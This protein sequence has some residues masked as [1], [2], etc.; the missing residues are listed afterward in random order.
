MAE[1]KINITIAGIPCRVAVRYRSTSP[2]LLF[3]LHGLGCSKD[4]FE[5]A[6]ERSDFKGFSL[7]A[8]DLLGFGHSD[9]PTD[10]S[11]SLEDHARV[12]ETVLRTFDEPRLHIIAHSMGGAVG[13]LLADNIL[14]QA[15]TF[16]NVEGNL[17]GADCGFISRK[18]TSVPYETFA[19]ELFPE[20]QSRLETKD[21]QHLFLDGTA[22]LAFYRSAQSLVE[23]SDSGRLLK[24][25][26][27]L[28]CKKAY[29]YG[30]RNSGIKALDRLGPIK[31]RSI[32][33]SGHFPMND[34]PDEFYAALHDFLPPA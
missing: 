19:K 15:E 8:P 17:I 14:R 7:L 2:H 32:S 9:K 18:A 23:W 12:C 26:K 4:S 29:F 22:P 16:V 27:R 1:S 31:K 21:Y 34:N 6:W 5:N 13:L 28:K 10:F 33:Q 11:Y 20:F 3:F 25:F 30:Q 24:K